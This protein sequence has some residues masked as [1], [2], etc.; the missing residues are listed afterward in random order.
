MYTLASA[1]ANAA[2]RIFISLPLQGL[3]C[4]ENTSLLCK[5]MTMGYH[6]IFIIA[7]DKYKLYA[8]NHKCRFRKAGNME[9][10]NRYGKRRPRKSNTDILKKYD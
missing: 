9:E 4:Y 1:H 10:K 3:L 5:N 2:A 8:Y 6:F 7:F